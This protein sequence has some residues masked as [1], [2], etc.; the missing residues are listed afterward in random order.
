MTIKVIQWNLKGYINNFDELTILINNINPDIICLQETNLPFN[1]INIICNKQY[2]GYFTNLPHNLNAKQGIGILVKRHLPHS[3]LPSLTSSSILHL[4]IQLKLNEKFTILNSY[5]PPDQ[6]FSGNEILTIINSFS[7]PLLFTGDFNAWGFAW[8]SPRTTSRGKNIIEAVSKTNLSLLNNGSPTHFSTHKTYTHIDLTFISSNLHPHCN[9]EVLNDLYSSDH[10]PVITEI[11]NQ[12]HFEKS[13]FSPKFK[14]DLANWELFRLNYN[15]HTS[16]T[17]NA[18]IQLQVSQ[19]TKSIRM[20]ANKAIPQ[21]KS[22]NY[23]KPI[24]TK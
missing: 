19:M 14:I 8:G 11:L 7:A 23:G 6:H 12:F 4:A 5:I 24:N 21:I 9:W 15:T 17:Q 3:L 18:D 13:K 2:I 16:F 1:S 20:A 22:K 10:F